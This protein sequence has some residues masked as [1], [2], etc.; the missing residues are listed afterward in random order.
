MSYDRRDK[1]EAQRHLE[2]RV[3]ETGVEHIIFN[4]ADESWPFW[5]VS[6]L[7]QIGDEISYGFNG[8]SYPCGT[9]VKISKTM[10]KITGSGGDTFYRSPKPRQ[11][12]TWRKHKTWTMTFGHT[13][14]R[15]PSF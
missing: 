14:K 11:Q 12:S 7:P 1:V 9:I 10:K 5:E 3:A 13:E 6:R 8:D 2:E 15:N 4:S